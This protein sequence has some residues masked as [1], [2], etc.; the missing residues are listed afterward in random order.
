MNTRYLTLAIFVTVT[1]AALAGLA[2]TLGALPKAGTYYR[3]HL[4]DAGGLV[5]GN[6]VRIAGVQIGQIKKIGIDGNKAL[7]ELRINPDVPIFAET[8]ASPQMKGLLG[9]KFLHLRQPDSGTTLPPGAE[10]PCVDPS[11]DIGEALNAMNGVVEGDEALYGPVVRIVKR[12]DALT[13]ALDEGGLP[14][15]RLDRMLG[16]VETMLTTTKEM[17]AENREDLRA[18]VKATRAHLENPK[19][20]RMIDNGDAVLAE[21]RR[22]VPGLITKG[23][24]L[25]VDG[26]RALAKVEKL[27][28][29]VD[30]SKVESMMADGSAA[31]KNLRKLSEEFQ[32]VGKAVMPMLKDLQTIAHRAAAINETVIRQFFQ[33]DGFRVRLA[34]PF[35]VRKKLEQLE[36]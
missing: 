12:F 20:G 6:A 11:V 17:L 32:G 16:D 33:V 9:E 19:I 4:D 15:E 3:L 14:K 27:I 25:F 5:E 2:W 23:K 21:L 8:C 34:V 30:T 31:V 7:L 18:I 22:E 35:G 28:D 10:I 29:A 1:L 24:Q 26:D 36:E 13:K